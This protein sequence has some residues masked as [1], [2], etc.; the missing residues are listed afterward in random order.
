MLKHFP[1]II[2]EPP[3]PQ[4]VDLCAEEGLVLFADE[5]Y[6]ENIWREGKVQSPVCFYVNVSL[7]PYPCVFKKKQKN[8]KQKT[9]ITFTSNF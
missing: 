8:K 2:Y 6:Q 1:I 4:I 3:P 7:R 5:V 9:Y